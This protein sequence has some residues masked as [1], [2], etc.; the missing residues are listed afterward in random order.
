MSNDRIQVKITADDKQFTNTMQRVQKSAKGGRESI[1]LLGTSV[2]GL[3][4]AMGGTAS[5]AGQL[6]TAGANMAGMFAIGGPVGLAI[7][8]GT[9]LLVKF[10]GEFTKTSEAAEKA[11]KESTAS[12]AAWAKEIANM[13]RELDLFGTKGRSRKVVGYSL[14][15][16][17]ARVEIANLDGEIQRKQRLYDESKARYDVSAL[18]VDIKKLKDERAEKLGEID[19]LRTRI[20]HEKTMAA[21]DAEA[22][23]RG[24][25]ARAK[26]KEE[27]AKEKKPTGV[28][29]VADPWGGLE[30]AFSEEAINRYYADRKQLAQ[31]E[32]DANAIKW[33]TEFEAL[34]ES[35]KLKEEA[36][37]QRMLEIRE[38]NDL[39]AEEVKAAAAA[40]KQR[41][42]IAAEYW[43]AQA[44][45]S[46]LFFAQLLIDN[47]ASDEA[48]LRSGIEYLSQMAIGEGSIMAI[49]GAAMLFALDPKGLPY[50]GGG[51]AL[52]ALGAGGMAG[53]EGAASMVGGALGVS[54]DSS[55]PDTGGSATTRAP[56][57]NIGPGTTG[58]DQQTIVNY[59]FG[60]PVFGNQDDA[61]R[62]V[63]SMNERGRR[64]DG[65]R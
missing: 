7:A 1:S 3:G 48:K 60:G 64:L 24:A 4:F 14:N 40:E 25:A 62:A 58:G 43:A 44:V 37:K 21:K 61:A 5:Q 45:N 39:K 56:T 26:A 42:A 27:K 30:G 51:L 9:L 63:S 28:A 20:T 8:A 15:I 12:A 16:Q 2:S 13:R 34:D 33:Q 46:T 38:E 17:E 11:R 6:V 36:H 10:A 41:Q 52:M 29:D 59:Y 19:H 18:A 22:D 65:L 35:N 47:E 50:L 32:Q 23:A 53:A 31:D 54:R 57:T 49:K 55:G